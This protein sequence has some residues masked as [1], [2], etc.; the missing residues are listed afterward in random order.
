MLAGDGPESGF[1]RGRLGGS[2]EFLGWLSG[3]EL[4]HAYADA[5]AFLFPS[6]TDTYGQVVVEAQASGVPVV[7]VAAGGPADLIEHGRSGLLAEPNADELAAKLVRLV[8]NRA[9]RA[10]LAGGGMAAARERT[11][12]R[13]LSQLADGYSIALGRNDSVSSGVSTESPRSLALYS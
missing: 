6:E 3:D 10:R 5:D 4:A 11:W 12:K 9:L 7:A 8:E 2:A 1:L 13:S